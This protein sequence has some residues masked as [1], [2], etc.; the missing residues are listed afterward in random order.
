MNTQV[1]YSYSHKDEKYREKLETHLSI[2]RKE[3]YIDEWSDRKISPGAN[4]EENIDENINSADIILLLVSSN[5]LASDYCYDTET[6]RAL[7]RHSQQEAIVIP[8]ILEPCL[9]EISHFA[10]EKIQ[11][12]PTD[13]KPI[14]TWDNEE[15]AWL[16]IAKGVLAVSKDI[17]KKKDKNPKNTQGATKDIKDDPRNIRS[18]IKRFLCTFSSY[19]FSPLRISKWG[20]KQNS[21]EILSKYSTNEIKNTLLALTDENILVTKIS[22]KGNLIYKIQKSNCNNL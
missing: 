5:F 15:E 8:I 13:G 21:F 11:A 19:Y 20:R 14:T 18:D 10:N 2:L 7:E 1:F 17:N 12:L 22:Q 16:N 4:W 6:I 9:W 3:K